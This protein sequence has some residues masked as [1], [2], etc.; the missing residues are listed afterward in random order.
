M[1][2]AE[3]PASAC[4][5][6]GPNYLELVERNLH[7]LPE[8]ARVRWADAMTRSPRRS[9]AVRFPTRLILELANT[10]NLDCPMCRVGQHGVNEHRF[11][12][13]A[14]FD[15]IADQMFHRIRE[16]R[17]NGLGEATLV[18]WLDHCVRRVRESGLRGEIIT[19]LTAPDPTSRMLIEAGFVVLV[20]WDAASPRLF[21]ALRRPSRLDEQR[22]RLRGLVGHAR[23]CRREADLHLLFTLQPLNVGEVPGVVRLAA[24]E[25]VRSVVVNVLK[26]RSDAWVE[27]QWARIQDSLSQAMEAARHGAVGLFMPDHLAGRP[28]GISGALPCAGGGCDR[29]WNEVVV[30]WNGEIQVCNMFNPFSYGDWRRH[31]IE[32]AWR[33]GPAEAFRRFVNTEHAHPYCRGCAYVKG[34][35]E[36]RESGGRGG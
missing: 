19:N 17:L 20:S 1:R 8:D 33:G 26:S 24:E 25:G 29:P 9:R 22:A 7:A 4:G 16:V 34:V 35:Y 23:C 30:R 13:R 32:R 36:A 3:V 14:L 31:G 15:D 6:P 2:I 28:T 27:R 21:E 11:M 10:C 18:P 12:E 5:V